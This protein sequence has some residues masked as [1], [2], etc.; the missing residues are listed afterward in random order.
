MRFFDIV[1]LF[2]LIA[3][4]YR[5][6]STIGSAIANWLSVDA[7]HDFLKVSLVASRKIIG[8]KEQKDMWG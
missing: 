5:G 2:H 3:V 6:H 7:R 8:E 4:R 1:R